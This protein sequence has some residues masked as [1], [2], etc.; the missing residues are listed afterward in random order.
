M[1]GGVQYKLPKLSKLMGVSLLAPLMVQSQTQEGIE[2]DS[3]KIEEQ[4]F[5][6]SSPVYSWKAAESREDDATKYS[7][8]ISEG[9]EGKWSSQ[10]EKRFLDLARKEALDTATAEEMRELEDLSRQREQKKVKLSLDEI[11]F[12]RR[13]SEL[14]HQLLTALREFRQLTHLHG[15]TSYT[16]KA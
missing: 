14:E 3:V 1:T 8:P 10:D 13:Q 15:R 7:F 9:V 5:V 6:E 16:N 11:L 12:R 2:I 4:A